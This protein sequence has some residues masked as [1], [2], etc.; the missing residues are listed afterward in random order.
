MLDPTAIYPCGI[1]SWFDP[2]RVFK[3]ATPRLNVLICTGTFIGF[4]SSFLYALVLNFYQDFRVY[5]P[6]QGVPIGL[7]FICNVGFNFVVM[8]VALYSP[9]L[10]VLP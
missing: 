8:R 4:S 2:C 5:K 6:E 10:N 7:E 9:V 1:V 3:R